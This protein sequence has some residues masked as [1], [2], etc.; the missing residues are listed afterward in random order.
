M[1]QPTFAPPR[2]P[3]ATLPIAAAVG[4]LV[5]LIASLFSSKY[6][7]DAVLGFEWPVVVYVALLGTVGYGPSLVWC[8]Y[9]SRRWGT[10]KFLDDV[11]LHARWS[12][13][14]WGPVVWLAAIGT[15]IFVGALVIAFDVPLSNNTD[16]ISELTTDRTYVVSIVITAVVAAPFVEE[17]VFRGVVMRGLLSRIGAVPTIAVQAALFGVAHLDPVRGA[18]NIGLV[19]VLTGVGA[20]FGGA[21]YLLRRI[22]PTIVAHAIFNG[23]VLLLVLT[24][25]AERLQ[26]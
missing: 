20:A 23:A 19:L 4:A 9:A 14:G 1:P 3:H 13:L 21:A 11:G 18:G 12:D 15:Q 2:A 26:N 6:V 7:L 25:V 22:G 10:G 17:I 24:G 5:V 16:G 8:R